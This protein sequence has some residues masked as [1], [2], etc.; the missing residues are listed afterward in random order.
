MKCQDEG[1]LLMYL[2]HE[3]P[4]HEM[5]MVQLHVNSC[6]R[7]ARRLVE[8]QQDWAFC[9]EKIEP[10]RSGVEKIEPTGQQQVWHEVQLQLKKQRGGFFNMKMKRWS[11]VAVS[12]V[13]LGVM[14]FVPSA[15]VAVADFLQVF[16]VEKVHSINISPA[17]MQQIQQALEKG[18]VKLDIE[19][20]GKIRTDGPSEEKN[21]Q[22][23][24]INQLAF[25]PRL[26]AA[27]AQSLKLQK[28]PAMYITPKVEE[29][30]KILTTLGSQSLLPEKL[31]GQTVVIKMGDYINATYEN[32]RM[33]A[34]PAPEVQVP[35]GIDVEDVAGALVNLPLWPEGV[36]RQ[37][38]A[39][40]DWQHT[41]VVPGENVEKV[42]VRGHDA[43]LSKNGNQSYLVWQEDGLIYAIE[44][45]QGQ[46][47][48]L[49]EIAQS[50]Q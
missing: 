17:D 47:A 43:V 6:P 4:V 12:V 44:P 5:R 48:D 11:A 50:L 16:R 27:V 19:S 26:P 13:L 35:S 3:L 9:C 33:I 40:D 28:V 41:L 10:I 25:Q 39:V 36:K 29:V 21:I 24:D 32:Y 49:Q 1:K 23:A 30:N 8:I 31:D 18:N 46:R 38:Q 37:L 22:A 2:E 45:L 42:T 14:A 34:G 7:C 15:R 20:L